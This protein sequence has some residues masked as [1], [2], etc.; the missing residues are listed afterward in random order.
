MRRLVVWV[1]LVLTWGLVGCG[2]SDS[3]NDD[4]TLVY[5]LDGTLDEAGG[6]TP[7]LSLGG[8]LTELGYGFGPNEGLAL[9]TGLT[10]SYTIEMRF[11][12]DQ[13]AEEGR[14]MKLLDFRDR[15]AEAGLYVY[16]ETSEFTEGTFEFWFSQGCDDRIEPSQGCVESL[17]NR[18]GLFGMPGT[19]PLGRLTTLRVVRDGAT[20]ELRVYVDDTLQTWSPARTLPGSEPAS[21]RVDHIHDFLGETTT[22]ESEVIH[23]LTDDGIHEASAG[24]IEYIRIAIP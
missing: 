8:V 19:V 9:E 12:I 23:F 1:A 7:L 14:G 4:W 24:V 13:A 21:E 15:S 11:Q 3:A 2:T 20:D 6:A 10:E 16:A 5:A 17:T 18:I 22:D